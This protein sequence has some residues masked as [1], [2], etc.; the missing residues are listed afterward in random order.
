MLEEFPEG[1]G[2]FLDVRVTWVVG[3]DERYSLV[4]C[5]LVRDFGPWFEELG[6]WDRVCFGRVMLEEL[7]RVSSICVVIGQFLAVVLVVQF[8]TAVPFHSEVLA[9]R[10][11][12]DT[13]T[14]VTGGEME[15]AVRVGGF[16]V[17]VDCEVVVLDTACGVQ[18]IHRTGGVFYG[19]FYGSVPIVQVCEECF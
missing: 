5:I 6:S 14:R 16:G 10:A 3:E 12:G 8:C 2:H 19:E 9:V 17:Y 4:F 15:I 18:V 13:M 1:V 11:A 7:K